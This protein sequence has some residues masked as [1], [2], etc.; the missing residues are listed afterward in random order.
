M[1]KKNKKRVKKT[2]VYRTKEERKDEIKK[3]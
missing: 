1:G 3:S 2:I